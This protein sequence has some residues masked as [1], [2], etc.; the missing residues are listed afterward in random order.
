[1]IIVPLMCDKIPVVDSTM[2]YCY[3]LSTHEDPINC[4]E[5]SKGCCKKLSDSVIFKLAMTCHDV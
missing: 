2:R 4:T 1:M 3:V 5:L